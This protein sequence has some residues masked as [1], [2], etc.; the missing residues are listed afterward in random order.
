MSTLKNPHA[1]FDAALAAAF[2]HNI[3]AALA[4]DVGSG[5]LTGL[6]VPE[7]QHVQAQVV[8]REEAVLCGAPWFEGVM[9]QVDPRIGIEWDYAEGQTMA[10]GSRVCRL[11]GMTAS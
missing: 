6:L 7:Q 8:V 3:A 10:A 5:D 4:E 11:H 9:R 1:P 2:E